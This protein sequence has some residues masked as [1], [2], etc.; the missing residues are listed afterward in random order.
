MST[1]LT[2]E[3]EEEIHTL[4]PVGFNVKGNFVCKLKTYVNYN[5]KFDI[6]LSES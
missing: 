3:L 5:T 1:F 6:Y 2:R 4:P